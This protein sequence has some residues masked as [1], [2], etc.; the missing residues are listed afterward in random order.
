MD[1]R[2]KRSKKN[3]EEK[4]KRK[5]K[6]EEEGEGEDKERIEQKERT[7]EKGNK[8]Y[9]NSYNFSHLLLSWNGLLLA[10]SA[11]DYSAIIVDTVDMNI[12]KVNIR[13]RITEFRS[14]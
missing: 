9:F 5:E 4:E 7:R 12:Q 13:P 2:E 1:V 10:F 8:S 14:D 6:R 3:R 11:S